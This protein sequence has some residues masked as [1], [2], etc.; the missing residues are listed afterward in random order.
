MEKNKTS[1][2]TVTYTQK[3]F[4]D[5]V[6][7]LKARMILFHHDDNSKG[8]NS[9]LSWAVDLVNKYKKGEGLFQL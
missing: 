2:K 7:E 4:D 1:E 5:M 6:T 3:N 9:G 8:F